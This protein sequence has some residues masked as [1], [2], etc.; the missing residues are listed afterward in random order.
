[1]DRRFFFRTFSLCFLLFTFAKAAPLRAEKVN[2]VRAV[3][4]SSVTITNGETVRYIGVLIPDRGKAFLDEVTDYNSHL[5]TIQRPGHGGVMGAEADIR[6]D[7]QLRNAKKELMGY[8]FVNHLFVNAAII[9]EGYGVIHLTP[10]NLKFKKI[11]VKAQVHAREN[12][13]GLWEGL[14]PYK[15]V[16]IGS[17][18]TKLFYR[19]TSKIAA[20][21]PDKERVEL[22]SFEHA[23]NEGF[24]I[25]PEDLP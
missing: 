21:I 9:T 13:R 10:P 16:F 20:S 8:V 5:V 23:L 3:S 6:Y 24:N 7:V 19:E 15:G 1:M 22:E 17:T 14:K 2:I 25:D 18:E 4:G 12:A 11:L